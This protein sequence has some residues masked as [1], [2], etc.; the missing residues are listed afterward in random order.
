MSEAL[1]PADHAARERAVH[2]NESVLVQA[3]A[4]SGKTTL[5]TQ[6]Y[7]RLLSQVDAPER[8]LALTFTRRAA[9]EMRERVLE[10][11]RAAV[12]GVRPA[13]IN[14]ATWQLALDAHRHLQTLGL[15]LDTQPA[16]LRIE[17]IDAFNAWLAAQLPVGAGAG[18]GARVLS[19]SKPLYLAAA[20]R[21][22]AHEEGGPFSAAVES[23]LA[24]DDQRWRSLVTLI[25]DML[26]RRDRWLRSLAGDLQAAHSLNEAQLAQVRRNFDADL[27]LL[28]TRV[29]LRARDVIPAEVVAVLPAILSRAA[30]RTQLP[31]LHPWLLDAGPLRSE[32]GDVPRWRSLA[33]LVLTKGGTV[34]A[35]P[36]KNEGFPPDSPDK[37]QMTDIFDQL[38]G[39]A[40]VGALIELS[41]LPDAFY[42]D[43][44][45][46]RVRD[47]SQVLILAAAELQDVFREQT[48]VDFAGIS[49]AALRALGS[50]EE[51]T[52]LNLRLD[53]RLQHILVDEF[54][55]TSDAQLELLRLLTAGW[56]AD[57]GRSIFCVGDPMQSIYAFRQAEVRAFLQLAD[58]GIGAVHFEVQRLTSNFRS[59]S[60]LV[61]WNNATFAAVL[62]AADDRA[63]GAI[64]FRPSNAALP[65][66]PDAEPVQVLRYASAAA[67]AQAVAAMIAEALA[68]HPQWRIAI[69]VRAKSHA[70]D[71]AAALRAAAIQFRA[72]DIESLKDRAVVRDILHLSCAL[73]HLGDRVS[74]LALLRAPWAGLPLAD[75]LILTQAA[76]VPWDALGD[77]QVVAQLSEPSRLRCAWLREVLQ[78][79]FEV[80]AQMPL[81]R[82][83]ESTWLSLGGAACVGDAQELKL[84]ERA[85]AHL[86][87]LDEQ[88]LPDVSQIPERFADL[89]ADHGTDGAVEIMTIHKSKGLEF[90]MVVLPALA[91][92]PMHG[93]SPMLLVHPFARDGR[94]GLAMAAKPPV[95]A[96]PDALFDFLRKQKQEADKL[97]AQRLLYVACTR[98]KQRL[99]LT[100][101]YEMRE[102]EGASD[103][104][105]G[106][107]SATRHKDP[108]KG[109]LLRVLWEVL[110][111]QS[112][113]R[114]PAEADLQAGPL[115]RGGPLWRMP[116][117]WRPP[118]VAAAGT[119]V[120]PLGIDTAE[121]SPVF[122]WA[123]ETARRIGTLVHAELHRLDA[124]AVTQE[125]IQ[126]RLEYFERWLALHGVPA[127][128]LKAAALRVLEALLAVHAD[129][130]GRWILKRRTEG[131]LREHALSGE[132]DGEVVNVVFDR[133]F[134]DAGIRWIVD[135]KTSQHTGGGLDEFLDREVERY[136]PQLER[137]AGLARR[138]GPQPV[139][140]G[141]YFPLMRAWREWEP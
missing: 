26:G 23:V 13:H 137:Y 74:W 72:V 98:A 93:H 124:A 71:I 42:S 57:D 7:L 122:D 39:A 80:R 41:A 2:A 86:H 81:S 96:E 45:W 75:L 52:D 116:A 64:Q 29:L 4:G 115:L 84:A 16:R 76:A 139:R 100:A 87:E 32:A 36:S 131:D 51:P 9:Q 129:S 121:A 65:P 44:Q 97:E 106:E 43:A 78:A 111:P 134:V 118:V 1:T 61:H 27:Q 105:P 70:R 38:R 125:Q 120:L 113:D 138:L 31:L 117:E 24:L 30:Q 47:V 92:L 56:Q 21:A 90:D 12:T 34:R 141:L 55:D 82:W 73:L 10:A 133:S 62:P 66:N 6:R 77:P 101:S 11:L 88:G 46:Q 20:R 63:R 128:R 58:D 14:S 59:A 3:P 40:A 126:S 110:Q 49:M 83:I 35:K 53:Y 107:E 69:L 132:L 85:F 5:L 102:A 18:S 48:A 108:A 19:E 114:P 37:P 136:R 130:K 54:Q 112:R 15:D 109:S 60:Q 25:A 104:Q 94:D 123:S 95:G 67:E 33:Q 28:I 119:P 8:I 91:R 89:F 17:T 22:L 140:A 79:A 103:S 68:A 135:Y 99:R 127:G 50:A